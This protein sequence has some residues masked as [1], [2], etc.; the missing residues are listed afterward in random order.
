MVSRLI[1]IVPVV[2]QD[3]IALLE[4]FNTI[5]VRPLPKADERRTAALRLTIV[6]ETVRPSFLLHVLDIQ[7]SSATDGGDH[8]IEHGAGLLR[9]GCVFGDS[10]LLR[11]RRLRLARFWK[12]SRDLPKHGATNNEEEQ[13]R[14]HVEPVY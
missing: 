2:D 12:R 11:R 6:I 4:Q 5:F 10:R 8:L 3:P 14:S 7:V 9:A 1:R 13:Q